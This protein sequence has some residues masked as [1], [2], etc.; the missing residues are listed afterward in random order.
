MKRLNEAG[1][2]IHLRPE[3]FLACLQDIFG[4]PQSTVLLLPMLMWPIF[5][6][7]SGAV[8]GFA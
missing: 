5:Y 6:F 8:Q 3:C 4:N 1:C 7:S 2:F